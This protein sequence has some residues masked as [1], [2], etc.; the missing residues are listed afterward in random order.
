MRCLVWALSG[1]SSNLSVIWASTLSVWTWF[2]SPVLI[3]FGLVLL[4]LITF[5]V[6]VWWLIE[7][8][9]RVVEMVADRGAKRLLD[10][11][12]QNAHELKDV[13]DKLREC[14]Q[15]RARI[16]AEKVRARVQA[17]LEEHSQ[18][19]PLAKQVLTHLCNRYPTIEEAK[20]IAARFDIENVTA[21]KVLLDL[22]GF[23]LARL[24]V[25]PNDPI[26]SGWTLTEKGVR[27]CSE[28]R[29]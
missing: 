25:A 5:A 22:K 16:A 10:Q 13:A 3:P 2:T 7:V 24:V 1:F 27:R 4:T 8:Q 6:I 12:E 9:R 23:G 26:E 18:L 20:D 11:A 17:E 14:E 15:A 19:Y 21:E 28:H 29:F